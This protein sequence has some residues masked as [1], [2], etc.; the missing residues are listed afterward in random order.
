MKVLSIFSLYKL[1]NLVRKKKD[2]LNLQLHKNT[3]I[4]PAKTSKIKIQSNVCYLREHTYMFLTQ[5]VISSLN[6]EGK[7]KD[8]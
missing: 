2:L 5:T 7:D 8:D 1:T 6:K 4:N 3:H